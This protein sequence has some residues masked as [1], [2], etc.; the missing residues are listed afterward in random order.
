MSEI[1][2]GYT[3]REC[4]IPVAIGTLTI[5]AGNEDFYYSADVSKRCRL[6]ESGNLLFRKLE[7]SPPKKRSPRRP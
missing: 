3:K 7:V 6:I 2:G 5:Y 4:R 1:E